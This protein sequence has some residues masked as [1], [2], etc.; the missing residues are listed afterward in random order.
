MFR[1]AQ[2]EVDRAAAG[3]SDPGPVLPAADVLRSRSGIVHSRSA[4]TT[5][6]ILQRE[7]Y[8]PKLR[9]FLMHV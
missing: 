8:T 3:Y 5:V 4:N 2:G 7:A 6:V 1:T 9:F